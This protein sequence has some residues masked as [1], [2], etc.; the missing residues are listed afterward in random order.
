MPIKTL[1]SLGKI[2]VGRV[3]GN[4]HIFFLPNVVKQDSYFNEIKVQLTLQHNS[5]KCGV[6]QASEGVVL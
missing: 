4:T 6:P 3:T 1:E 2:W 5:P